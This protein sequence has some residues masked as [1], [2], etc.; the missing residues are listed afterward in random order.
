M[1]T[2]QNNSLSNT[3]RPSWMQHREWHTGSSV[4]AVF[5]LGNPCNTRDRQICLLRSNHSVHVKVVD[6]S[7]VQFTHETDDILSQYFRFFKSCK[8]SSSGHVRE[9]DYVLKMSRR[10]LHFATTQITERR[11]NV[12]CLTRWIPKGDFVPCISSSLEARL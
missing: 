11:M 12:F 8:M 2:V 6:L 5:L 9:L 4:A 7:G 3:R 10:A 1:K